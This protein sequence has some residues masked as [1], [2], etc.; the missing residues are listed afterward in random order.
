LHRS[1][2]ASQHLARSYA[3]AVQQLLLDADV[4]PEQVR[5]IACTARPYGIAGRRV[6]GP[7]ECAGHA[8]ELSGIDVVPT[9]AVATWRPAARVLRCFRRFMRTVHDALA[10]ASSISAASRT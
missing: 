5:A 1:A 6:H 8:A 9:S 4:E 3:S 7:V 10:R 2:I